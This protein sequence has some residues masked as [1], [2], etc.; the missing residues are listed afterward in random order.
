MGQQLH[1]ATI[2]MD[3]NPAP[4]AER[5]SR[6]GTL[7]AESAKTGAALIVLPEIFNTGYTYDESLLGQAEGL[8]GPTAQWLERQAAQHRVHLA[9]SFL[10]RDGGDVFNTLLLCSPEGKTW[11]YDKIYP[12]AWERSA[13]RGS[14][15]DVVVADTDLGRF[16][17]LVC[18]DTAHTQLWQRYAGQ[19]DFMLLSSCP[20]DA[21]NPTYHLKDGRTFE[22]SDL[23][24]ARAVDGSEE[25]L[26]GS[27]IDEQ[28]EWLGVP[29]V[30]T[31]GC[32]RVRTPVPRSRMITAA[33]A[34]M[35]PK[36]A[37]SLWKAGNVE[38]T[39]GATPGAKVLDAGGRRLAELASSDGETF[40]HA[41]VE[42]ADTAPAPH[43]PQPKSRLH[44]AAYV[45]SDVMVPRMMVPLYE[46]NVRRTFGVEPAPE[47]PLETVSSFVG[48]LGR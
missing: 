37:R 17:M 20:I 2:Q 28:V 45:F 11:R 4:T 16:G 48:G 35:A 21:T 5:L 46:A 13:F 47:A 23:P 3:A 33:L 34:P 6:A 19:V 31:V 22:F 40:A 36:L 18:W 7:V 12:W 15:G 32:G 39:A 27:M 30:N 25:E 14:L 38:M 26:F 44:G 10:V 9:G 42:L 1:V 41:V 8:D 24:L 29:A 43:G